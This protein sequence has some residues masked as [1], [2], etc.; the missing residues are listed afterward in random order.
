MRLIDEYFINFYHSLFIECRKL[1]EFHLFLIPIPI[2]NKTK[3][4]GQNTLFSKCI[5][6]FT[7]YKNERLKLVKVH[8][9]IRTSISFF[10]Q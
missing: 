3:I 7:E 6:V 10:I 5:Y 4:K 2:R 1:K 8:E 9:N